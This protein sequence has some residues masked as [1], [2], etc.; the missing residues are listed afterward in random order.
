MPGKGRIP[1]CELEARRIVLVKPSALG[2]IIHSLPVL[3]ALRQRYPQAYIAWVVNRAYAELLHGHPDLDAVLPFDR[4]GS[5]SGLVTAL[6]TYGRFLQA[7]RQHRFD[8]VI[9]L[10]GLLRSGVMTAASG[11]A[12]RV[13][14]ST[15]REGART[16][17]TDVIP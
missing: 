10:Q 8:L 9:D 2:D 13:G 15:A 4:S 1:L 17:Y 16:F 14:L 7:L 5:A 11:A 3:T 6:R 12:R